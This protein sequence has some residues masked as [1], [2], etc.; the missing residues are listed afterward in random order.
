MSEHEWVDGFPGKIEVCDRDGVLLDMN[1]WAA[2]QE[3]GR[4]LLGTNILDCHPEPSRSKLHALLACGQANVY[5]I[6]KKGKKK[7]VYQA[8]WFRDG[9]YAGLV[10]LVLDIPDTMPHFDRDRPAA[11][12][13]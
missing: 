1:D 7:L 4:S 8:P 9:Q 13:S 12:E 11:T 6:Q 3:G 5:T 2:E 10:E